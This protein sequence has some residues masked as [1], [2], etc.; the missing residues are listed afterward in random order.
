MEM[1]KLKM[2]RSRK[3]LFKLALNLGYKTVAELEE[4]MSY[5]EFLEWSEYYSEEPFMSD[6]IEMQLATLTD[7]TIKTSTSA[8]DISPVDFMITVSEEQKIEQKKIQKHKD[9]VEKLNSFG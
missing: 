1:V 2:D 9:L 5:N 4:T 6:R 8:K 3:F 7:V